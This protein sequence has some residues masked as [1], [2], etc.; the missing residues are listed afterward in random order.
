MQFFQ[1]RVPGLHVGGKSAL[2]LHRARHNQ[3]NRD[4]LVVWGDVRYTL[5]AWFIARFPARYVYASLF[6]WPNNAA[7]A[8]TLST[9]PGQPDGLCVSVAE[10]ALLE[11]LY[12]AGT[13]QSLEEARNLFDGLRSP[14]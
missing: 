1:Q 6:D 10:R 12:D 13:S 8:K 4:T 7:P 5:P 14:C 2:A 9:P 3:G 11:M